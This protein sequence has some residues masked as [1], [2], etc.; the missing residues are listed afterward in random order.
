MPENPIIKL[1]ER[2]KHW[3]ILYG[4]F[5]QYFCSN[6]FITALCRFVF[7][8]FGLPVRVYYIYVYCSY[9][10]N[11]TEKIYS[12]QKTVVFQFDLVP[13]KQLLQST[14]L[15][16]TALFSIYNFWWNFEDLWNNPRIEIIA[17]FLRFIVVIKTL[18]IWNWHNIHKS[19]FNL[20]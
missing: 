13:E 20:Y 4:K 14:I 9:S 17:M 6:Q 19:V 5:L 16:K 1:K 18:F 3:F 7:C 8:F 12:W 15:Y 2:K 10:V 11:Q